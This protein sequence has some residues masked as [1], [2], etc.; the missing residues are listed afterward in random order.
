MLYDEIR[1]KQASQSFFRAAEAKKWYFKGSFF[2]QPPVF[3]LNPI[4]KPLL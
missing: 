4:K 3:Y 2:L 1:Q